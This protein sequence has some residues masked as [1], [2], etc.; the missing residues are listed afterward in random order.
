MRMLCPDC[1][2]LLKCK[3]N[4]VTVRYGYYS[5]HFHA[6]LY[7]CPE[8]GKQIITGFAES[9]CFGDCKIDYDFGG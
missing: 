7:E 4:G 6:D 1:G 5:G 3:K 9:E 2:V 8:C